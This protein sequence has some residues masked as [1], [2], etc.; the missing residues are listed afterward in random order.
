MLGRPHRFHG[1]SSVLATY[2]Q[3]KSVRTDSLSLH[4]RTN[5]KQHSYRVA[6]VVSRKVSKSAVV[7]NR[8]RR[9]LYEA[10]RQTLP[11][12]SRVDLIFTVYDDKIAAL[13][14]GE[15]D[16]KVNNLLQKASDTS[17]KS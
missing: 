7:R 11:D 16:A 5:P 2:K 13:P 17:G 14:K 10:V 6:V 12:E 1:H 9:R 3:A 8:I 4:Y 15:L